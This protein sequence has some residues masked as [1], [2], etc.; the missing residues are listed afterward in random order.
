MSCG[1]IS[2]GVTYTGCL[3]GSVG[4]AWDSWVSVEFEPLAGS[5]AYFKRKKK[6]GLKFTISKC[7]KERE[8]SSRNIWSK[9]KKKT[10]DKI[11]NSTYTTKQ[12]IYK[13][14][15]PKL[16]GDSMGICTGGPVFLWAVSS[17]QLWQMKW[18]RNL[19]RGNIEWQI[20]VRACRTM[21]TTLYFLDLNPKSVIKFYLKK[22]Y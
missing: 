16:T 7:H 10:L 9:R 22:K 1:A 21:N 11:Y 12:S 17:F 8:Y 2:E 3:A 6:K 14:F 19:R 18:K 5:R 15:F 13:D 4:R 20:G